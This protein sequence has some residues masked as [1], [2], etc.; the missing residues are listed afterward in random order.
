MDIYGT[1]LLDHHHG[2]R[3]RVIK[4]CRDNDFVNEH[5][6]SLYFEEHPF[7][8]EAAALEFVTG[9]VLDIGCGAGR[10]LLW[11]QGQGVDAIG[12]VAVMVASIAV[13]LTTSA[14]PDLIVAIIMVSLFLRSAQLILIQA[15]QEY[16]SDGDLG[17]L[18]NQGHDHS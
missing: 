9:P 5:S 7:E 1:A 2:L 4:I 18:Q 12:N 16:R 14:W 11:L 3:D 15:W 10:H 17:A 6:A 8:Q 13:W